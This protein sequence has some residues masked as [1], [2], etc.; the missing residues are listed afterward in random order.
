MKI[1]K[2]EQTAILCVDTA[3]NA[4]RNLAAVE[5]MF[6]NVDS[7][8]LEAVDTKALNGLNK[9]ISKLC[10]EQLKTDN[11]SDKLYK[12]LYNSAT[13]HARRLFFAACEV[14]NNSDFEDINDA[15]KKTTFETLW[16]AG[17]RR[18]P[19]NEQPKPS[20]ATEQPAD[21]AWNRALYLIE[22]LTKVK[23]T[24]EEKISVCAEVMYSLGITLDEIKA[25]EQ[26]A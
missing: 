20:E 5:D 9:Q 15:F 4:G 26:I 6:I 12:L 21:S 17:Q 7:E 24:K 23:L 11:K 19:N 3:I 13:T 1:Y 14:F 22:Q 8:A 25:S 16:Q 10:L 2:N 18:K